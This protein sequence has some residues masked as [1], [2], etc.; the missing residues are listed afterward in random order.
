MEKK[1]GD[2]RLEIVSTEEV[3]SIQIKGT[4]TDV[5]FAW[6]RLTTVV[7]EDADLPLP[8]L[9][10]MCASLEKEL[11]NLSRQSAGRIRIRLPRPH[12]GDTP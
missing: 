5:I 9:L 7:A 11:E 2:A 4:K 8:V 6:M 12:K 3:E 10:A 1:F